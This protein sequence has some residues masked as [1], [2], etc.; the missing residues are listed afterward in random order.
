MSSMIINSTSVNTVTKLIYTDKFHDVMHFTLLL[1]RAVQF[2]VTI[3]K[4]CNC[5]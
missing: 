5:A 1:L 2:P 4:S 3:L